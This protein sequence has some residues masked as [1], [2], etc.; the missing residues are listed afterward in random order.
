MMI[1]QNCPASSEARVCLPL[2]G[3]FNNSILCEDKKPSQKVIDV[4]IMLW[5][6]RF[7]VHYFSKKIK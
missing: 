3:S 5:E 7:F 4:T 1:A 6:K 2:E